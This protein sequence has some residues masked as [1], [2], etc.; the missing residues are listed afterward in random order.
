MT[1][2]AERVAEHGLRWLENNLEWFEPARW[3]RFLPPRRFRAA[4][5][6]EL[7]ILVRLLRGGPHAERA[8]RIGTAAHRVAEA[9]CAETGFH[10]E[11]SRGGPAF[12]YH[13]HLVALLTDA[14]RAPA[15]ARS[16]VQAVL[17]TGTGELFA[18]DRPALNRLE[19]RYVLDLGGFDRSGYRTDQSH[20]N[21]VLTTRQGPLSFADDEVYALTHV[22][23]YLSDFGSRPVSGSDLADR[24]KAGRTV[25]VLLGACLARDDLDLA[26]ELLLCADILGVHCRGLVEHGWQRIAS[27]QRAD[28]AVPSPLHDSAVLSKVDGDKRAAY[29]FGTCFHTTMVAVM[30]ASGRASRG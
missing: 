25:S 6:L 4:P 15:R 12:A 24:E 19:L 21:S 16:L 8:E 29:L 2:S 26:G 11:L 13:A 22:L 9:V 27:A 7:L 1:G 23:F 20:R 30:A 28:G 17:D 14:G 10:D 18:A 3:E 5:L